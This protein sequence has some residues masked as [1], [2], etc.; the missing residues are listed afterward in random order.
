MLGAGAGE[1]ARVAAYTGL[2]IVSGVFPSLM[3]PI[4]TGI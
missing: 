4:L 3:R 1:R 2:A